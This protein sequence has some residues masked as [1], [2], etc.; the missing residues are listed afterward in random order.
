MSK[1]ERETS[2]N[3]ERSGRGSKRARQAARPP[4]SGWSRGPCAPGSSASS[5]GACR[6]CAPSFGW[7]PAGGPPSRWWAPCRAPLAAAARPRRTPTGCSR[8]CTVA[9]QNG[10]G[11]HRW[12]QQ[13]WLARQRWAA[14]GLT[15]ACAAGPRCPARAQGMSTDQRPAA[16]AGGDAISTARATRVLLPM[17]DIKQRCTKVDFGRQ[18]ARLTCAP[19]KYI[20]KN[21]SPTWG[22]LGGPMKGLPRNSAAIVPLAGVGGWAMSGCT[23]ALRYNK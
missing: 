14:A 1:G 16:S 6:T 3:V 4:R 15:Y 23:P 10:H 11:Q 9:E 18:G 20:L 21:S 17:R 2:A 5:A 22:T 8:G 7:S 12:R 19:R 13:L